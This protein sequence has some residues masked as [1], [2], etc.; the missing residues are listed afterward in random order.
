MVESDRWERLK[1]L[2]S[3]AVKLGDSERDHYLNSACKE[4][5]ELAH[6]VELLV[7]ECEKLGN[8]LAE[9]KEMHHVFNIGDV[10][11]DRFQIV[12]LLGTG[13]MGEVYEAADRSLNGKHIAL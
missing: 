8:F 9:T 12:A 13:G 2:F 4:D 3:A 10:V 6:E 7:R 1:E 5:R 11:S